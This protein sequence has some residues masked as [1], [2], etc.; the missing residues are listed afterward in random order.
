MK[1]TTSKLSD[2]LAEEWCVKLLINGKERTRLR[3]GLSELIHDIISKPWLGNASTGLLLDEI[4]ERVDC[5]YTTAQF[6]ERQIPNSQLKI[7]P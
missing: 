7:R 5:E 6:D 3:H 2:K 1:P 4:R